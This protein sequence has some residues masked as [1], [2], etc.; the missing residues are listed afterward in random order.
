MFQGHSILSLDSKSRFI[1]PAKFRKFIKPEADNK[2][3]ITRGLDDCLL[4]YPMD[5]WEKLTAGLVNYNQF[6]PQQRNFIRQ[7][8]MYVHECELD[9]QNRILIPS[10][11]IEFGKLKR[12]IM[13]IGLIDKMEIWNPETK[14]EYDN[15]QDLTFEEVAEKVSEILRADN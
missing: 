2:L 7:F 14:S 9:S 11:L 10:Q 12:E 13:I 6:N 8:F 5:E 15:K 3:I 4:L 1:L